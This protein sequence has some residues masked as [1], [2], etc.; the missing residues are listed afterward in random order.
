MRMRS[1]RAFSIHGID[2]EPEQLVHDTLKSV[3]DAMSHS[4]HF[5]QLFHGSS[6]RILV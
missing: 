4:R 3:V 6:C 1:K 5:R 2:C